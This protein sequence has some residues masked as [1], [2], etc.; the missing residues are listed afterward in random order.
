MA[1]A[2]LLEIDGL[3]KHFEES[4]NVF[5]L[6]MRRDPSK[7]QAVDGVS[8]TLER[9]DSI[10]VIGESGCGKTTLLLTLIGLHDITGGDVV[11]KGTPMSSFDSADWKEY[12][13]N[14]QV[15]FQDPFN[16]LD[17][18]MT[19]EESLKEPL[20]IHDVGNRDE[21]DVLRARVVDLGGND[22]AAPDAGEGAALEQQHGE[23]ANRRPGR[24]RWLRDEP[25]L[26]GGRGRIRPAPVGLAGGLGAGDELAQGSRQRLIR[27]RLIGHLGL[28]VGLGGGCLPVF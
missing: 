1:D 15:I 16:S 6:L 12:R 8:F 5:D 27:R 17:P 13:S 20:E 10:A 11:Y 25:H 24:C 4:S 2:P 19:V 26:P 23:R 7:I 14:V 18:K 28:R 9:N 22:E 21:E 3:E